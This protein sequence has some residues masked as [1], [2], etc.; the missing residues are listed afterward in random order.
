M[1]GLVARAVVHVTAPRA[2]V[3][4]RR[5]TVPAHNTLGRAL[6]AGH[7]YS[8][9]LVRLVLLD[10]DM[11]VFHPAWDE[12]A[13]STAGGLRAAAGPDHHDDPHLIRTVRELSVRSPEFR[14]LWARHDIR[15]RTHAAKRFRHPLVGE[16]TLDQTGLR[17]G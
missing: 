5:M 10:P 8:G 14:Q 9:D 16:L 11:R 4:G 3:L 6:F 7:T 17:R 2:V 1:T 12:M 15:Q 13:V